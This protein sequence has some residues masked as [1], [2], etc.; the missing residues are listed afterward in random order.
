MPPAVHSGCRG[1][2]KRLWGASVAAGRSGPAVFALIND[3]LQGPMTLGSTQPQPEGT[4]ELPAG[5]PRGFNV[6]SS[7]LSPL[8]IRPDIRA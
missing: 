1:W 2:W 3:A 7:P 4:A 8:M 6:P 5:E